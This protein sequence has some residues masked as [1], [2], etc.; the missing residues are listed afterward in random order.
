MKKIITLIII[1]LMWVTSYAQLLTNVAYNTASPFTNIADVTLDGSN[2][3]WMATNRGI[4]ENSI[5][6][7]NPINSTVKSIKYDNTTNKIYVGGNNSTNSIVINY[8]FASWSSINTCMGSTSKPVTNII[9][10][11]YTNG[12]VTVGTPEGV[13]KD[14][15]N[16]SSP[17]NPNDFSMVLEPVANN[18]QIWY[19]SNDGIINYNIK[20]TTYTKYN[21]GLGTPLKLSLN[22]DFSKMLATNTNYGVY[23]FNKSSLSSS[24]TNTGNQIF[25]GNVKCATYD[26]SDNIWIAYIVKPVNGTPQYFIE[27]HNASDNSINYKLQLT[28][29]IFTTFNNIKVFGEKVYICTNNGLIIYDYNYITPLLGSTDKLSVPKFNTTIDN[30]ATYQWYV[31]TNN[32][33]TTGV[34]VYNA[35]SGATDTTYIPTINGKYFVTMTQNN[36]NGSTFKS[37]TIIFTLPIITTGITDIENNNELTVYPNP[38]Y[39]NFSIQTNFNISEIIIT[40]Q[41]GQYETY[42]YNGGEI[43]TNL[44]GIVIVHITTEKEVI[45]KKLVIN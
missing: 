36:G 20:T 4:Y 17:Y 22:S 39:G 30:T 14:Y 25:T 6:N 26:A 24:S 2:N 35:I 23:I 9:P 42:Q 44:K 31:S 28:S 13:Y 33:R 32:M 27:R 29:G 15:T 11:N 41:M 34:D 38:N 8:D 3:I 37:D 1:M 45:T 40:N 21:T 19:A 12:A 7:Y 18:D 5:L 10:F 16:I 43:K